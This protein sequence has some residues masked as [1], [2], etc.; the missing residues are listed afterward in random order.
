MFILLLISEETHWEHGEHFGNLMGTP[1]EIVG[2]TLGTNKKTK[3]PPPLPNPHFSLVSWTFYFQ[4]DSSPF[5]TWTST[6]INCWGYL[7]CFILISWVCLTIPTFLFC[8]A[9]L[10]GPLQKKLKLWRLPKI[11]V[12]MERWNASPFGP[13]SFFS[14]FSFFKFYFGQNIWD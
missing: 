3:N 4:N 2:N 11:E 8:K 13:P 14:F 5:S 7:F 1:W 10:I 9:N 6:I 12:S